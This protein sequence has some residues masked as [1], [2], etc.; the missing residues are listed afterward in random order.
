MVLGVV[1]RDSDSAKGAQIWWG[2]APEKPEG[3]SGER[4][5]AKPKDDARP[6]GVPSRDS[7]CTTPRNGSAS[8]TDQY[9]PSLKNAKF[10]A[11]L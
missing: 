11:N 9:T 7:A 8:A 3:C 2:E 10:P 5:F 4:D 6:I 1:G